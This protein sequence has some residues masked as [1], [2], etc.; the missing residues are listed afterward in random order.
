MTIVMMVSL[1]PSASVHVDNV[2]AIASPI[3]SYLALGYVVNNPDRMAQPPWGLGH[4]PPGMPS[5]TNN[6]L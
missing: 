2:T 3:N 4:I 5:L 6:S 1:H